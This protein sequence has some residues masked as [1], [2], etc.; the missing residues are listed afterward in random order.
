[1]ICGEAWDRRHNENNYVDEAI[2][3]THA[4]QAQLNEE[5]KGGEANDDEEFDEVQKEEQSDVLE[6]SLHCGNEK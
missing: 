1:M 6:A 3:M 4:L 2:A 5:A